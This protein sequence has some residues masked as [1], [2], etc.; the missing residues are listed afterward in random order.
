[1]ES[2]GAIFLPAAGNRLGSDVDNVQYDGFCWSA[3]EANGNFAYC[4]FFLSHDAGMG[5]CYRS[6]GLSVRLVKDLQ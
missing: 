2:A 3:T 5:T 1:M 6:R 4:L